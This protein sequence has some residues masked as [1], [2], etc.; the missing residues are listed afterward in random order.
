MRLLLLILLP[1]ATTVT[2][3]KTKPVGTPIEERS[4]KRPAGLL[5]DARKKF[6]RPT[7]T[8][9]GAATS[10]SSVRDDKGKGKLLDTSFQLD[11][12]L[13][14]VQPKRLDRKYLTQ[15]TEAQRATSSASLRPINTTMF[16]AKGQALNSRAKPVDAKKMTVPSAS[17][18]NG[19]MSQV[20]S[21][22]EGEDIA[23]GE[24]SIRQSSA[25]R[26]RYPEGQRDRKD[27]FMKLWKEEG[28]DAETDPIKLADKVVALRVH[29]IPPKT[30]AK[31]A[32]KIV[33]AKGDKN[34]EGR[35]LVR[36]YNLATYLSKVTCRMDKD[37]HLRNLEPYQKSKM[38]LEEA[39]VALNKKR[40]PSVGNG[41]NGSL[42]TVKNVAISIALVGK[43]VIDHLKK[44]DL[45]FYS[46]PLDEIER[47]TRNLQPMKGMASSQFT[48][49][50]FRFIKVRRG[51]PEEEL[52]ILRRR[53]KYYNDIQRRKDQA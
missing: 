12:Y 48:R 26:H 39:T 17:V 22:I 28:L 10:R 50:L 15:S 51:I 53:R 20:R 45:A 46:I 34:F 23:I 47:H 5:F 24:P 18:R 27:A 41:P 16:K 44:K 49:S 21:A 1:V 52:D 8:H 43:R 7:L 2:L 3:V 11:A 33:R 19:Q 4:G 6:K 14:S 40:K 30:V 9:T 37:S 31:L 42:S 29:G 13:D 36:L 32:A 25:P 38:A 35:Y